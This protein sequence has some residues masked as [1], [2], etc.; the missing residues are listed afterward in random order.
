MFII[1]F[2]FCKYRFALN[3]RDKYN[4]NLFLYYVAKYKLKRII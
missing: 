2:D 3:K 4:S 1:A